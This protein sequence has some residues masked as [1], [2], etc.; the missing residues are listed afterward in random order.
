M[1]M[2]SVMVTRLSLFELV[3]RSVSLLAPARYL[4]VLSYLSL[5]PLYSSLMIRRP[6][7]QDSTLEK[8]ALTIKRA[9]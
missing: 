2:M 1:M 5:L 3:S 8:S 9:D 6:Q 4:L 7:V